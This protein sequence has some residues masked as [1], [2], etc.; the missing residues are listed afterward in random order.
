VKAFRQY[1]RKNSTLVEII[2]SL[3]GIGMIVLGR[4]C[5][6]VIADIGIS[7]LASA[8]IVFLTDLLSGNNDQQDA[9]KWGLEG[10]YRTRGEMN[11]S[12]DYYLKKTKSIDIIAFGLRSWRD[13]QEKAVERIL[14]KGGTIRII[15][16]KPGCESLN[17][18]EVDE[19]QTRGQMSKDINDLIEWAQ[20]LNGKSNKGKIEI[21]MHDHQ[22]QNFLFLMN[23]R[24]FTGPYLFRKQSQQTVSFEYNNFG[25]AYEYY[26]DYFNELWNNK[27][28]CES[29]FSST[30]SE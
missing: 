19:N 7:I 12:C 14:R 27:E 1:I 22:P 5:C 6:V 24:L 17:Q 25:T 3:F 2:I 20:R 28:F 10:V 26:S 11:A 13:S 4:N 21:R 29:A 23:N 30:A 8:I 18:R 16:M 15:T 9:R